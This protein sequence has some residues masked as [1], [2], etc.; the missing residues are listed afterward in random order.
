MALKSNIQLQ[1][2][3]AGSCLFYTEALMIV[4][5]SS[6]F[7]Y[8]EEESARERVRKGALMVLWYRMV[9][10]SLEGSKTESR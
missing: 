4:R 5:R 9:P 7:V 6:P 2:F 8:L 3:A 10:P 1:S